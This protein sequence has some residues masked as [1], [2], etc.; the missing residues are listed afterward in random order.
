MNEYALIGDPTHSQKT[1][2]VILRLKDRDV[3]AKCKNRED[4]EILCKR[5]NPPSSSIT[6]SREC[7]EFYRF[8]SR[9]IATELEQIDIPSLT[10]RHLL[11]EETRNLEELEQALSLQENS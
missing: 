10:D 6:I 1:W 8:K 7:A 9:A 5:L 11:A 3:I 2:P 4:A